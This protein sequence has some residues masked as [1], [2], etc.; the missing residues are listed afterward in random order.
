MADDRIV[1]LSADKHNKIVGHSVAS[2]F[3]AIR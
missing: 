2:V 3:E 1:L